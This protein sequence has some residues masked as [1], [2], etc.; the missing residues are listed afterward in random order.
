[1]TNLRTTLQSWH[2]PPLIQNVPRPSFTLRAKE[3]AERRLTGVDPKPPPSAELER[4]WRMVRRSMEEG[5]ALSDIPKRQLDVIPWLMFA[6]FDEQPPLADNRSFLLAFR[7]RIETTSSNRAVVASV[8]AFLQHYPRQ[9]PTFNE[10]RQLVARLL[11]QCTRARCRRLSVCAADIGF[12]EEK[13]P[14]MLWQRLEESTRPIDEQLGEF[15]LSGPRAKAGFVEAAFVV[16][17]AQVRSALG[18]DHLQSEGLQRLLDFAIDTGDGVERL[19]FE[20][21][22]HL[23]VLAESL[24]LPFAHGAPDP[25]L[26]PQIHDFLMRHFGDPRLELGRWQNVS[27][28]AR[29]VILGWLVEESLED[30][31]RLLEYTARGDEV[32]QR[33]WRYR[34]AFWTAYLRAGVIRD[35]WVVLSPLLDYQAARRMGLQRED[36]GRLQR[37]QGV[38]KNHAVLILRI[39]QLLITDWSHNGKYRIWNEGTASGRPIPK[40]YRRTYSRQE[41]VRDPDHG[42]SHHGSENGRWQAHLASYIAKQT[43]IRLGSRDYMPHD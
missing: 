30:F 17:T 29:N 34:K 37:G 32:A 6:R 2:L 25:A 31:F 33:H 36:Y 9:S 20:L 40:P 42:G 19:R 12:F 5:R 35:A 13:G 22:D 8:L 14:E 11:S 28:E 43:G 15:C 3:E 18:T 21:P 38:Q 1:M 7:L 39:G 23:R 10:W 41:L 4:V 16:A 24:L 27:E 26:K